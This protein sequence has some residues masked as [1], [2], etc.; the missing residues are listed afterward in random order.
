MELV[1]GWVGNEKINLSPLRKTC[2]RGGEP[3]E[4]IVVNLRF[5][6]IVSCRSR[7]RCH[8]RLRL[9]SP[10]Y[11]YRKERGKIDEYGEFLHDIIVSIDT[12]LEMI[13]SVMQDIKK[14]VSERREC[15]PIPATKK[16][17]SD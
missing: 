12:T 16:E 4:T 1:L 11:S 13:Y 9:S 10:L 2:D 14:S 17:S 3:T 15:R 8:S 7:G 5:S 6:M